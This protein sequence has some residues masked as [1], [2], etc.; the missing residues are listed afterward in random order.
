LGG[1]VDMDFK[2]LSFSNR[3]GVELA[4]RMDLPAEGKPA[5]YVIFAHCFT[6]SKDLKAPA[7]ISRALTRAGL[8]VLRFDFT[9]LG[10]S[11]G[12]FSDSNFTTQVSDLLDAAGFLTD[13][14]EAPQILVGHS[15]GG[16][17]VLQAASEIPSVRAVAVIGAP[18][19]AAHVLTHLTD[20]RDEIEARGEARVQ[21]GGRPFR[22]KKQFI[23][24]L[25]S[26]QM[27]RT[28]AGLNRALMI[29]HSPFDAVVGINNAAD[30][31][32]AAKHPKS[33]V[34]LDKADHLLSDAAD[35]QYAGT[36]I[37]VWAER[38]ISG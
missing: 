38:Y 31:F 19:D 30:I 6:C 10:E 35:S 33:F 27:H 22:I 16:A 12:E 13:T 17:A 28:I 11:E 25:E 1:G 26:H 3:Q 34:S 9:G 14:Y 24:D 36:I 8:A 29:L 7:N 37:A 2:K 18:R 32:M 5:A 20:A 21:L 23:D 15:L 4:A